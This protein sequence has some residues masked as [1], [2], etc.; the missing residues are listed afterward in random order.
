MSRRLL[1]PLLGALIPADA[2]LGMPS[3]AEIDFAA[4]AAQ[5]GAWP[6]VD[7]FLARLLEVGPALEQWQGMDE[8]ACLEH[9]Q[10]F[11]Q[12]ELRLFSSFLTHVFRAYYSSQAVQR[13]IGCG[14]VPP[15][16][17]GNVL[18]DDDWSVLEP[19]YARGY[20]RP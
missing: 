20:C 2:Q 7:A 14:A 10:A 9:L 16:P 18:A 17:D 19:V 1:P 15:F 4:Y 13:L 6:E 3:A 12:R 5:Q 11:R 8:Q